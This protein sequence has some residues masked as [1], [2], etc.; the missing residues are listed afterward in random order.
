MK[1]EKFAIW[2]QN[3]IHSYQS[4][5]DVSNIW[6]NM[7][8]EIDQLNQHQNTRR[9][10]FY[11]LYLSVGFVGVS[12]LAYLLLVSKSEK[13]LGLLNV[14]K[15]KELMVQMPPKQ[16]TQEL[17]QKTYSVDSKNTEQAIKNNHLLSGLEPLEKAETKKIDAKQGKSNAEKDKSNAKQGKSNLLN[18]AIALQKEDDRLYQ[19]AKDFPV[20][21]NDA[22]KNTTEKSIEKKSAQ[23]DTLYTIKF[24]DSN[25]MPLTA[26]SPFVSS[27]NNLKSNFLD[28]KIIREQTNIDF[29]TSKD[30][31]L[32]VSN[33]KANV[34]LDDSSYLNNFT[35]F[36]PKQKAKKFTFGIDLIG[37]LGFANKNLEAKNNLSDS[38]FQLRKNSE[39]SLETSQL[40]VQLT[41]IHSSGWEINSGIQRSSMAERLDFNQTK[42][43]TEMIEGIVH[44]RTNLN[45]QLEAVYGLIPLTRTSVIRKKVYNQYELYGIPVWIGYR[46]QV[47]Q[48]KIGAK[49]GVF[50]NLSLQTRG[51]VAQEDLTGLDIQQNQASIFKSKVGLS[52][53][54][55]LSLSRN[56]LPKVELNFSTVV[57]YFPDDFSTQSYSL[58]QKYILFNGN[59]GIRYILGK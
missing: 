19:K 20:S 50:A 9:K 41:L 13:T 17:K 30:S 38:L 59:L 58:S 51:Q 32:Y 1:W 22:E 45:G 12:L 2:L 8:T 21:L 48:W 43:E 36:I 33:S 26:E 46:R 54:F 53:Q 44:Y 40:G 10:P 18:P 47:G 52:Y 15:Q 56:I 49:A 4:P 3:K 27:L 31:L 37:G 39:T 6:K 57:Q 5:V 7:E 25:A 55:G 14:E 35:V 11:L 23:K 24:A 29:L 28:E 42:V 34:F 16:Q